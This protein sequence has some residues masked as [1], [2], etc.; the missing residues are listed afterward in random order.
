PGAGRRA[1]R[2]LLVVRLAGAEADDGPMTGMLAGSWA[3]PGAMTEEEHLL[4]NELISGR[5][6]I[7]F[8]EHKRDLLESRLRPRL[9][10]L[11][12][13]RYLDYYLQLVCDGEA[14]REY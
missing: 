10:A 11:H 5:F 1:S 9:Q 13:H 14:E 6:G 12:L 8:P 2:P 4:L 7:N 3:R